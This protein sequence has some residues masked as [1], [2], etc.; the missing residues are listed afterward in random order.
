MKRVSLRCKETPSLFANSIIY[1]PLHSERGLGGGSFSSP[2]EG[3]GEV[4][5]FGEGLG[6]RLLLFLSGRLR[7]IFPIDNY[8]GDNQ[9]IKKHKSA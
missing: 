8:N 1:S 4:L 3:L 5:T 6:V 2:W 9:S 7:G